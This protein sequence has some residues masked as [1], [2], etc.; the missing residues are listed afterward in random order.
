[1]TEET[2]TDAPP[3][4]SPPPPPT[5]PVEPTDAEKALAVNVATAKSLVSEHGFAIERAA[6]WLHAQMDGLIADV[7]T[8]I[9]H[10]EGK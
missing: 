4:D 10:I 5:P 7:E 8:A 3:A 6:A 2:K 1:M 9:K